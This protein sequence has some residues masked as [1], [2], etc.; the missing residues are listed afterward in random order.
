MKVTREAILDLLGKGH[1]YHSCVLTT[2]NF[3]PAYFE[4]KILRALRGAGVRNVLVMLDGVQYA[5]HFHGEGAGELRS[6][7]AYGIWPVFQKGAYHPKVLMA[8]G[9]NTGL[10]ALGSGNLT[11]GGHGS[12]D[13]IWSAFHATGPDSPN[14][15]FF[16]EAWRMMQDHTIS[17]SGSVRERLDWVTEQA[18]WLAG[19]AQER[20]INVDIGNG[21]ASFVVGPEAGLFQLVA[22]RIGRVKVRRI[23][24]V[25]P[26]YDQKGAL[27]AA[28]AKEW[29]EAEIH[30]IVDDQLGV[31]PVG[32]A[33]TVADHISWHRWAD[34]PGLQEKP[35]EIK[36]RR[37]HAKVVVMELADGRELS[38][39]GSANL[40]VAAWGLNWVEPRNSEAGILLE[41]RRQNLIN[42]LG[43]PVANWPSVSLK[44]LGAGQQPDPRY[45]TDPSSWSVH[46]VL[47]E[48]DGAQL[49]VY[50]SENW[51]TPC[52]LV[53]EA[54]DGHELF[55]FDMEQL[56]RQ[57]AFKLD[58]PYL[59]G[60]CRLLDPKG[61]VLSNTV[62]V[63]DKI[64]HQRCNPDPRQAKWQEVQSRA[65][66]GEQ[67]DVDELIQFALSMRFDDDVL[68]TAASHK[69]RADRAKDERE[70]ERLGSYEEFTQVDNEVLAQQRGLLRHPRL[71]IADLLASQELNLDPIVE[72][73]DSMRERVRDLANDDDDLQTEE[74]A[75][76]KFSMADQ[77]REQK[78]VKRFLKHYTEHIGD[79]AIS[80][81][82][83][84]A[85]PP[86]TLLDQSNFLIA[87]WL[88][89]IYSA[90]HFKDADRHSTGELYL[91]L[92]GEK[93]RD[94]LKAFSL[95]V[96]TDHL[97][98]CI[99][100]R[101][102]Y[103]LDS[104][105]RKLDAFTSKSFA[106][107][108]VLVINQ[109]WVEREQAVFDHLALNVLYAMHC[110]QMKVDAISIRKLIAENDS[111]AYYRAQDTERNKARLLGPVLRSFLALMKA[112]QKEKLP[113]VEVGTLRKGSLIFRSRSGFCMLERI[114][115]HAG[116]H[117]K[118]TLKR[119]GAMLAK[120]DPLVM[121][122]AVLVTVN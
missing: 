29:P 52:R 73:D 65:E 105:D 43:L 54:A 113:V 59:N 41:R 82:R 93:S 32:L 100:E 42:E 15:P 12:N 115:P 70:G 36:R 38:Y 17:A 83:S 39:V 64:A 6:N 1:A 67:V 80:L 84:D 71:L 23:V 26:Y 58:R 74:N 3:D 4:Y 46:L 119:P 106:R 68:V 60:R 35:L 49:D 47:V 75:I 112:K 77:L 101:M 7:G 22:E 63:Q 91:H 34:L 92:S 8:V 18:P 5:K 86:I 103:D 33:D 66:A 102:Q 78:A 79:R 30:A 94:N 97:A 48:T 27:L 104:L 45:E 14:A 117:K 88:V 24:V 61:N 9:A 90:K 87:S 28:W 69:P 107:A 99:S 50:A 44:E 20:A 72:P 13:E 122:K 19:L 120:D 53:I 116:D 51:S 62:L 76:N 31:L 111:K 11:S 16:A 114:E 98:T 96:M 21:L 81:S 108:L 89:L 85:R 118:V 25:S 55:S 40:S 2:Y 121:S 37:L 95:E 109:H 56:E 110:Q 57:M 10:L